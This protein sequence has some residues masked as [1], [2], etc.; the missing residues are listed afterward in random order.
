MGLIDFSLSGI[1]DLVKDVREAITGEAIKDPVK[2]AELELK[3]KQLEQ[4]VNQ[5][6]ININKIEAQNPNW[7]IAGARPFI[8]W[9]CGF[10]ILYSFILAPFLH[11]AFMAFNIKFP[12]PELNIGILFNLLLS[13]LG[14]AG[15]RTYEKLK[16]VNSNHL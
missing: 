1:G 7:F 10:A 15:L 6:Q 13:M 5:G 2:K 11:S 14:L 3:L 4:A 8:I 16:G 12:L 9:V